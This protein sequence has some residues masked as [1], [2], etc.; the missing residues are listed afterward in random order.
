MCENGLLKS[1]E[2]EDVGKLKLDDPP[3]PKAGTWDPLPEEVEAAPG[4][5]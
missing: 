4:K 1:D 2:A 5:L 3:A